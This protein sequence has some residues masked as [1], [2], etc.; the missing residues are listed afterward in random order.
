MI[1]GPVGHFQEWW[2]IREEVAAEGGFF[3]VFHSL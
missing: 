3:E 2:L 1:F